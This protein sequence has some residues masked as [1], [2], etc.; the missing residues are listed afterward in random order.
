MRVLIETNERL[1]QDLE[2][3]TETDSRQIEM[4]VAKA[5]ENERKSAKE[6]AE[7]REREVKDLHRLIGE[8]K[9]ETEWAKGEI[10]G[11]RDEL[12]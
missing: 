1:K 5:L 4:K 10:S 12:K 7:A 3:K 8:Y 11:V 6:E 2:A 9:R